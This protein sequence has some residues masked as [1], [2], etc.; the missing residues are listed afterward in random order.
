[1]KL[2]DRYRGLGSPRQKGRLEQPAEL[3]GDEAR[4]AALEGRQML[5]VPKPVA[6]ER[7]GQGR[8]RIA[9]DGQDGIAAHIRISPEPLMDHTAVEERQ[10]WTTAQ[11]AHEKD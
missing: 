8:Q 7:S 2:R 11:P 9:L 6:G 5:D 4:E 10:V 1:M 3:V